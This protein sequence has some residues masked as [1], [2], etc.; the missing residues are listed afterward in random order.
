M[1]RTKFVEILQTYQQ[2][3]RDYRQRYKQRVERQFRI[4]A[5]LCISHMIYSQTSGS[6]KPDATPEEIDEVVNNAHGGGDQ[7]FAQAVRTDSS[8]PSRTFALSIHTLQLTTSTR[9]GESRQAYREVQ[10][11]HQDILRIE[12]TLEELAQMF[13]DVRACQRCM[14]TLRANST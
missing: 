12:R 14:P 5:Y 13:N 3:E 1:L 11:R 7:I 4:G 6:V 10:D 8:R 9:Y 2:V